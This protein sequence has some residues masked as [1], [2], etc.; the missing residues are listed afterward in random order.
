MQGNINSIKNIKEFLLHK[1]NKQA[2][3]QLGNSVNEI[4]LLFLQCKYLHLG[5]LGNEVNLL[6]LQ[7]KNS[8]LG[9]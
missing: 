7:Y 5:N 9:N 2:Y 6:L 4:N 1:N 3:K 8:Q